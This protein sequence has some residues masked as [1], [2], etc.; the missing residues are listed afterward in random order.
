MELKACEFLEVSH[1]LEASVPRRGKPWVWYFAA[2]LL[3]L[4]IVSAITHAQ[5]GAVAMLIDL[6]IAL[7]IGGFFVFAT[8]FS[9][10]IAKSVALEHSKLDAASELITLRRWPDAAIALQ[11][12][13]SQPMRSPGARVQSLI[14]LAG[15]LGRYHRFEEAIQVYDYLLSEFAVDPQTQQALKLGRAMSFL[16]NDQLFDADRAISDLRRSAR[17]NSTDEPAE[18]DE[19]SAP[20]QLNE[21]AGLA[22]LEM[23]RD[24]KT[25]HPDE[26]IAIFQKSKDDIRRQFGHRVAD[27]YALAAKAYDLLNREPEA[28]Q[29]FLDATILAPLSE[30]TRRYP[31]VQSLVRKFP[32]AAAPYAES[33]QLQSTS[34]PGAV[35]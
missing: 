5:G 16:R 1:L 6:L 30:L 28:R 29:A 35:A 24:V 21:S 31:E 22:L 27:A 7:L 19:P 13:L 23:Y 11:D 15:V 8:V 9:S 20:V 26:A 32:S 2:G 10:R 12:L 25:G 4:L 14:Y 34:P 18:G 33:T 3:F 17:R